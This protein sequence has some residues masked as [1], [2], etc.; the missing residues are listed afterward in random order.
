MNNLS[1]SYTTNEGTK[2]TIV[3]SSNDNYNL[4]LNG[5]YVLANH[6]TKKESKLTKKFKGTLLGADIGVK[7]GGFSNIAILATVIALGVIAAMYFLWRF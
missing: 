1:K 5:S 3:A 6:N 7:S 4:K 2:E